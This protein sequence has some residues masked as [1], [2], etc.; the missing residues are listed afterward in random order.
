VA[1]GGI[2]KA[3]LRTAVAAFKRAGLRVAE[4]AAESLRFLG[5]GETEPH[6][7]D[8]DG[9]R[10]VIHAS[11]GR[12]HVVQSSDEAASR[13]LTLDPVRVAEVDLP[14]FQ[15]ILMTETFDGFYES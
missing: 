6:G 1:R 3:H 7:D 15:L 4:R 9:A 12:V 8:A 5:R 2:P 14:M 11:A 13:N 10:A